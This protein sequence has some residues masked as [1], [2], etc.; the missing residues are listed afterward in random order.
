MKWF[1]SHAKV[2]NISPKT[3]E[4]A[5]LLLRRKPQEFGV[6]LDT[7][8]AAR[9][10]RVY[11]VT[12]AVESWSL[13]Q[14][15]HFV[16]ESRGFSTDKII[17]GLK[18]SSRVQSGKKVTCGNHLLRLLIEANKVRCAEWLIHACKISFDEVILDA[19]HLKAPLRTRTVPFFAQVI[20][21][22]QTFHKGNF[23]VKMWKML[24]RVFPRI[25]AEFVKEH[26]VWVVFMSPL[27][28]TVSMRTLGLTKDDVLAVKGQET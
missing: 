16:S 3:V 23:G 17:K 5:V 4:N 6:F 18:G 27:H 25:T 14:T 11:T 9:C 10:F 24:L 1:L 22:I 20:K 26:L 7:I 12:C 21:V 19:Y 8:P 15:M 13:S 2:C 28:T